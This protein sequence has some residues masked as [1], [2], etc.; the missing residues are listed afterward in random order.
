MDRADSNTRTQEHTAHSRA[1]L[2]ANCGGATLGARDAMVEA[3]AA[4][5]CSQCK[6][7][8]AAAA[9]VV[10]EKNATINQKCCCWKGRE[11]ERQSSPQQPTNSKHTQKQV[12]SHC[13]RKRQEP[14]SGS[15]IGLG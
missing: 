3:A 8:S 1:A 6:I 14:S 9:V 7:T 2:S 5:H 10:K 4:L 11:E 12:V 15:V 13:Q